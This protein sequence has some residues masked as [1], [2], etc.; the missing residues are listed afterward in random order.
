MRIISRSEWGFSGWSRNPDGSV[1]TPASVPLSE[2]S[3]FYV[4]YDGA[5]HINITGSQVPQRIDAEHK[6]NGWAGIGY[7]FVVDQA[8]NRFEGRGWD[9]QGAHCPGHNRSAF[10]VQI[11]IGGDQ[12]PTD[13]ALNAAV[14]LYDEAC[15]RTGRVLSKHGHKD[16]FNTDCPGA[17]LYPWVQAGMPRPDTLEDDMPLTPQDIQLL[18][19]TPLG[20]QYGVTDQ[21][22]G[23]FVPTLADAV[24]GGAYATQKA[25][26]ALQAVQ[27]LSS[28]V[29]GLKP[30]GAVDVNALA[31][32]VTARVLVAVAAA[33]AKAGK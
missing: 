30:G 8:G 19:N 1:N 17:V 24:N 33:L 18:F 25:Q 23:R 4:H 27:A 15:R 13:A 2:R 6:G 28:K 9:L 12:R 10:G 16:G 14:D 32:A 21:F 31:D 7:H 11:A 20:D 5:A 22:G 3:E 29:D 26:E